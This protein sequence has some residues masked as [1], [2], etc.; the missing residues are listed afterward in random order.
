MAARRLKEEQGIEGATVPER[1]AEEGEELLSVIIPLQGVNKYKKS[2]SFSNLPTLG[3]NKK[4]QNKLFSPTDSLFSP[5]SSNFYKRGTGPSG[6]LQKMDARKA[7]FL[8]Q[9]KK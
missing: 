9:N 3:M 2:N 8:R 5:V 1:E 6:K 7:I 4:V